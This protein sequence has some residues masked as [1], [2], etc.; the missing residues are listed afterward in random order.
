[1]AEPPFTMSKYASELDLLRDKCAWQERRLKVA[2]DAL[3]HAGMLLGRIQHGTG[4]VQY[5]EAMAVNGMIED[6]LPALNCRFCNK[7]I[8]GEGLTEDAGA[9]WAHLACYQSG[10]PK[11]SVSE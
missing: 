2:H 3:L 9:T 8:S 11:S 4:T 5:A 10:N 7:P 6:A 1:M